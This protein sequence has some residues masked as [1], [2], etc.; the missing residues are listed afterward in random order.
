MKKIV[1][2]ICLCVA[3]TLGYAQ[4]NPLSFE[5]V[6]QEEGKSA[7][8]L[9]TIIKTWVAS[10]FKSA[11]DVIQMDD[12][13]SGILICKGNISYKAPGGMSYRYIDGHIN[14]TLKAQTKDGRCKIIVSDFTHFSE[15]LQEAKTWSFGLITDRE[16]YKPSGLQDSRWKKTWPD[17]QTVSKKQAQEI[18]ASIKIAISKTTDNW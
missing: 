17:L 10:N 14:F 11:N 4:E 13:E 9:Y 7:K 3:A 5:E 12:S 6:I 8:E 18:I 16:K 15:D 2:L 1:V